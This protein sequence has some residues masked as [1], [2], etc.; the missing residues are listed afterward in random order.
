MAQLLRGPAGRWLILLEF[1]GES[2]EHMFTNRQILHLAWIQQESQ[3]GRHG[4]TCKPNNAQNQWSATWNS[5]EVL[6]HPEILHKICED[7]QFS[8]E[9][10]YNAYQLVQ[11][12]C[13]IYPTPR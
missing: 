3:L 9:G 2:S 12:L 10:F 13:D 4:P 1:E 11:G 7:V 8:G 5:R 6:K